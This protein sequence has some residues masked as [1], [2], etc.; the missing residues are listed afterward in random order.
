VLKKLSRL[1]ISPGSGASFNP[2]DEVSLALFLTLSHL[3]MVSKSDFFPSALDPSLLPVFA[4]TR[5]EFKGL[6]RPPH[7]EVPPLP[8]PC[9]PPAAFTKSEKEAYPPCFGRNGVA[10]RPLPLFSL[11]RG[12]RSVSCI[13]NISSGSP[14][15][16]GCPSAL[17]GQEYGSHLST[18]LN[19]SS[20]RRTG[21]QRGTFRVFVVFERVLPPCPHMSHRRQVISIS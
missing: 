9:P 5:D 15:R 20:A 14:F 3:L 1:P 4:G 18:F 8:F 11:L 7:A 19:L 16:S 17:Q 6:F 21:T 12:E 13:S 10:P 2:V